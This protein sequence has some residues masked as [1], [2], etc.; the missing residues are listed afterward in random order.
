MKHGK[1][2][3]FSGKNPPGQKSAENSVLH[4]IQFSN[5]QPNK[6]KN[7]FLAFGSA[8][9]EIQPLLTDDGDRGNYVFMKKAF[10]SFVVLCGLCFCNPQNLHAQ[11]PGR[12]TTASGNNYNYS[13]PWYQGQDVTY[14]LYQWE[15][16]KIVAICAWKLQTDPSKI[17]YYYN[18]RCICIRAGMKVGQFEVMVSTTGGITVILIEII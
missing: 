17:W 11:M 8:M 9:P 2:V 6:R 4:F 10:F 3:I 7:N 15:L 1:T 12:P 18:N 13:G 16:D 5:G 14:L